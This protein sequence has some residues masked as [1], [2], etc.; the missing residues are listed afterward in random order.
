MG[1]LS[2]WDYRKSV[3]LSRASG[4]V[5]DYQ[6]K[7]LVGESSGSATH[8]VNCEAKGLSSFNDLRFTASDGT[9]ILDYWIESIAGTTPN[10]LA[11]VWVEFDS[12]GTGATTFYMYYGNAAAAAYSDGDDTFDLF[13]DFAGSAID[14]AKWNT[15]GTPSITVAG[16]EL[17]ILQ[18]AANRGIESIST[19]GN[20][21]A[22][23]QRSHAVELGASKGRLPNGF[24][25]YSSPGSNHFSLF[26]VYSSSG[27]S[28]CG[29][30]CDSAAESN[31][32]EFTDSTSYKTYEIRRL[33]AL[34]SFWCND[35][36]IGSNVTS[37]L[38]SGDIAVDIGCSSSYSWVFKSV[39]DWIL[40][41]KYVENEPTFGTWGEET[42][43]IISVSGAVLNVTAGLSG[44]PEWALVNIKG[45]TL[46][47]V[48]NLELPSNP[49]SLTTGSA[50]FDISAGLSVGD[51][52]VFKQ[53]SD[54]IITY[55]CRLCPAYGDEIITLPMSSF[56]GRF[57]SGDPSYLSVVVPGLDYAQDIA[58][59]LVSFNR[60]NFMTL[61]SGGSVA[62]G[63]TLHIPVIASS[64]VSYPELSVHI[65]KTFADG[66]QIS[67]LLMAVN[68]ENINT[69]EG[70]VN[71]S[72]TLEGHRTHS[73]TPKIVNLTGATYRNTN[74]GKIRYRCAPDMYLRPGDTVIINDETFTADD[75]TI[76][77]S[78]DSETFEFAQGIPGGT[79]L[80][81]L[82]LSGGSGSGGG[83]LI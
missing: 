44:T 13:D 14:A 17:T 1:W 25:R 37:H 62:A 38:P 47:V 79:R 18:N 78:V 24:G 34:N 67:E 4:T 83:G 41:R 46:T 15:I 70:D 56:Q 68:L 74:D 16:S 5:T 66:N 71:Q 2:G 45:C 3:T 12:I 72:M 49:L 29:D 11:T 31:T 50:I 57:K 42:T 69:N 77:K 40:V 30:C 9:T 75:I 19:F 59:L 48:C 32:A 54:Y 64:G 63:D 6:M 35:A 26:V 61:A 76:Y 8:D 23:R 20:G 43:N 60:A 51:I 21:F 53:T 82:I 65:V 39:Y 52:S 73:Y 22:I 36:Q 33:S 80:N 58:D 27:Q 81:P 55:I 10:Q 7:V 28:I